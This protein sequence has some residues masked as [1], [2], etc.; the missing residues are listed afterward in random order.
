M[1]VRRHLQCGHVVKAPA[2]M[3]EALTVHNTKDNLDACKSL[4]TS[5]QV[6]VVMELTT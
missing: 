3:A 4:Q 5:C 2:G 6:L 1:N